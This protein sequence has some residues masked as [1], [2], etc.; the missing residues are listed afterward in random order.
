MMA[1]W[2]SGCLSARV[3]GETRD[4]ASVR[5]GLERPMALRMAWMSVSV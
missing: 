4:V 3:V 5:V 1:R 2:R